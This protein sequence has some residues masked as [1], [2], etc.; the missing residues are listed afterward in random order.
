MQTSNSAAHFALNILTR[1]SRQPRQREQ[2]PASDDKC[3]YGTQ[4]GPNSWK[5]NKDKKERGQ[6]RQKRRIETGSPI[7]A[8]H[9]EHL[10]HL[11]D[12]FDEN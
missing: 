7:V 3:S 1:L 2:D 5:P 4:L 12:L 10:I 8:V 11:H 9:T 6:Q